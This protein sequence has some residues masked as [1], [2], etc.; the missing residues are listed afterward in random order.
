MKSYANCGDNNQSC[1]QDS[2]SLKTTDIRGLFVFKSSHL[3]LGRLAPS[4]I[5]WYQKGPCVKL[6]VHDKIF[7]VYEVP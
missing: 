4:A 1:K 2:N 6:R 5:G 3:S 7:Q